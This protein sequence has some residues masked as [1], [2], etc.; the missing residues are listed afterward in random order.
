MRADATQTRHKGGTAT[1]R[2]A[3]QDPVVTLS[4]RVPLTFVNPLLNPRWRQADQ[5][6]GFKRVYRGQRRR[7]SRGGNL[8]VR[9]RL[10]AELLGVAAVDPAERLPVARQQEVRLV[11]C[12]PLLYVH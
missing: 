5:Q 1:T 9:R 7:F 12:R 4:V 8:L 11:P 10:V 6:A 2:I 3:R